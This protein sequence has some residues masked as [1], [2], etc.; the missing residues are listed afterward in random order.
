MLL[1]LTLRKQVLLFKQMTGFLWCSFGEAPFLVEGCCCKVF[2]TNFYGD[3]LT[4]STCLIQNYDIL[5]KFLFLTCLNKS[6][7]SLKTPK[8]SMDFGMEITKDT[9]TS[10]NLFFTYTSPVNWFPMEGLIMLLLCCIYSACRC[11]GLKW[12]HPSINATVN[13]NK[14]EIEVL[15]ADSSYYYLSLQNHCPKIMHTIIFHN[16]ANTV[17]ED[18]EGCTRQCISSMDLDMHLKQRRCPKTCSKMSGK[19]S[20]CFS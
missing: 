3:S 11:C 9:G 2:F 14:I 20:G 10:S 8:D 1:V 13:E 19:T 17:R 4:S 16:S 12:I 6:F 15:I 5:F 18:W 7:Q